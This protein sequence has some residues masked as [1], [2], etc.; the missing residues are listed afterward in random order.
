[1]NMVIENKERTLILLKP[2]AVKRGLMGEIIQRFERVGLRLVGGK[3]LVVSE[4]IARR[5]YPN[6]V[7]WKQTVGQRTIDDCEKY[8]IDVM[9]NMGTTD[10]LEVGEIVKKWN[11]DF[12]LSG[13]VLAMV[14]QGVNAVERV[15][16]LVGATVPAKALPGTV[17]GDYSLDS[18]IE[19]NKR[20]R[21]IYNLVHASGSVEE[22]G[23][24][25]GMWFKEDEIFDDYKLVYEDLYKY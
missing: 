15:R 16:S 9:A 21:T 14:W 20:S 1:M 11:E 4:E 25:I 24:E 23:G 2:D 17:R 5:H 6:T 12:L 3:F 19:A 10:P 13:P 7:E 18:A 22:A 8:G